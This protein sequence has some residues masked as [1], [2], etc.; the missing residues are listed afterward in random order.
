MAL[1]RGVM[2]Y[3]RRQLQRTASLERLS[4]DSNKLADEDSRSVTTL[5]RLLPAEACGSKMVA[6]R[7][8]VAV[9]QYL[10]QWFSDP[11]VE[12]EYRNFA[13]VPNLARLSKILYSGALLYTLLITADA[14]RDT[15]RGVPPRWLSIIL[16]VIL[17]VAALALGVALQQSRV[18][19][20][21]CAA[22]MLTLITLG[23]LLPNYF[24]RGSG[25]ASIT[26]ETFEQTI[27]CLIGCARH[28]AWP[29]MPLHTPSRLLCFSYNR[30]HCS[31]A[32]IPTL[33][34]RAHACSTRS[35][36]LLSPLCVPSHDPPARMWPY[37]ASRAGMPSWC[38]L[39]SCAT[40]RA[41][42]S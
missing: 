2:R 11:E 34:S 35:G 26:N 27:S 10:L 29:C 30:P 15:A 22:L 12:R 16:R 25:L 28:A 23:G 39:C 9:A 5:S 36:L 1:D 18:S 37:G 6:P 42:C 33:P 21:T 3:V 7:F 8:L 14:V 40:S 38:R 20:R 17:T 32:P 31:T 13:F 24:T 41:G 19:P 4:N